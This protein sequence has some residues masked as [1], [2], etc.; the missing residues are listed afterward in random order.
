MD[1]L[2]LKEIIQSNGIVGAGG[3]GFPSYAKLNDGIDTIILNCA[4]CEPLL[5]LHQQLLAL[6][7]NEIVNTLNFIAEIIGAKEVVI[8]TKGCY[9]KTVEAVQEAIEGR[10]FYANTR[11]SFLPEI[12]PAGDEIITIYESTG[13]IVKPG[14]LP[15][16]VGVIVY[17]VETIYNVYK[18]LFESKPVTHKYITITGEVN[19]P[20]TIKV[21]IGIT[22]DEVIKLVGGATIENPA[23]IHGGPM[24]GKLVKG[25]DVVTKTSNGLLVLP[26]DQY[27]VRKKN[28]NIAIS[29]KRAKSVCCQCNRCT[30]MCPRNVIGYPIEPHAVMRNVM[31]VNTADIQSSLNTF[32]CSQCGICEMYACE[33]SLSPQTLIN[34][35]RVQLRN[36]G[37]IAPKD[38]ELSKIN[39]FRKERM[40]SVERLKAR[41]G[42]SKYDIP[43]P[44]SFEEITTKQVKIK[45]SQH[46][47]IPSMPVVE[48]GILVEE[49]QVIARAK[50][51]SL[52]VPCHSS[53]SGI[54][55]DV[56][57]KY[58]IIGKR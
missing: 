44:L 58:I 13:R 14:K 35:C 32:F 52:S 37:I 28:Q 20:K 6:K 36:N 45:L 17:N 48:K 16:S 40:I 22:F 53:M 24:T 21:P 43:A 34:E 7:A 46:I 41:L 2:E 4:E 23:Y 50:E 3:A 11:I 15:L 27:I 12:Y 49:G 26:Q 54:V 8:A 57:E 31:V 18:A 5:K 47:G 38:I 42:L 1:I 19:E 51:N 56:N 9:I 30:E 55:L 25:I 39:E 10:S 33:Q 29:V